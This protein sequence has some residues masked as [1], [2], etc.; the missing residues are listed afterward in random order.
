[1]F[2][3]PSVRGDF[4]ELSG[5]LFHH[6]DIR[7]TDNMERRCYVHFI[8]EWIAEWIENFESRDG[9]TELA[10]THPLISRKIKGKARF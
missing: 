1:M 7:A 8:E 6:H 9:D 10:V 4:H 3:Y 5:P 2:L